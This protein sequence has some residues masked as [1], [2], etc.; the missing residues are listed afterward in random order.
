MFLGLLELW[1]QPWAGLSHKWAQQQQGLGIHSLLSPAEMIT[2]H[3]PPIDLCCCFP[4]HLILPHPSLS[5]KKDK[6]KQKNTKKT[7]FYSSSPCFCCSKGLIWLG[8]AVSPGPIHKY[9]DA[10]WAVREP[11][12]LTSFDLIQQLLVETYL[13][14]HYRKHVF[15][16]CFAMPRFVRMIKGDL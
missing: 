16:C 12:F 11:E 6:T 13:K 9:F 7:I 5:L 4:A 2:G 10:R 1:L 15:A 8:V 14:Q 3:G